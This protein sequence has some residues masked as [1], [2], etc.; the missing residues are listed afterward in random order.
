MLKYWD[1]MKKD[2]SE[3]ISTRDYAVLIDAL[4]KHGMFLCEHL[5]NFQVGYNS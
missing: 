1:D 4:G 5:S 2:L 3:D